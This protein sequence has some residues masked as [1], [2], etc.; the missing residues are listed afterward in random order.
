MLVVGLLAGALARF[1]LPGRDPMGCF[2]TALLGVAGSFA[3]GAIGSLIF[4]NR[5]DLR[6]ADSFF[7]A[8][9][10]AMAV[11]LVLRLLRR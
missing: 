6:Q 4:N 10:G 8:V 11:L 7:G 2:A 1:L 3:G 9:L 5:I